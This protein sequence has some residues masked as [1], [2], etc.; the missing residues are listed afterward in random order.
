VTDDGAFYD[1]GRIRLDD[2][3]L[4]IRWYYLWGK[5]CIPYSAI[6]SIQMRSLTTW[7]GKWRIWGSGDFIHWFNLDSTRPG[8]ETAIEIHRAGRVIPMITPD[9]ADAVARILSERLQ[10]A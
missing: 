5:K 2:D 3:G 1:D 7:R 10:A 9:D 6:R 8:K 4:T